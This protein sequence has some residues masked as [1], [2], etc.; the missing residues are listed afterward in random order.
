MSVARHNPAHAQGNAKALM[1]D[2]RI[3]QKN[4]YSPQ[5]QY[6]RFTHYL[7]EYKRTY[8][9]RDN[10][11]INHSFLLEKDLLKK[12]RLDNP[13]IA[14]PK[15][16]MKGTFDDDSIGGDPW[17]Y[18]RE[19]ERDG[20][21]PVG[22]KTHFNHSDLLSE[23]QETK[24]ILSNLSNKHNSQYLPLNFPQNNLTKN[25]HLNSSIPLGVPLA[26]SSTMGSQ[27]LPNATPE[28]LLEQQFVDSH[29]MLVSLLS[30]QKD[31]DLN[32]T[33]KSSIINGLRREFNYLKLN[34]TAPAKDF[35]DILTNWTKLGKPQSVEEQE[36]LNNTLSDDF[37]FNNEIQI[38]NFNDRTLLN[39]TKDKLAKLRGNVGIQ[40]QIRTALE[41][42]QN[43]LNRTISLQTNPEFYDL[44][45]NERI[46]YINYIKDDLKL[47]QER[48]DRSIQLSID[49]IQQLHQYDRIQLLPQSNTPYLPLPRYASRDLQTLNSVPYVI[50][51]RVSGDSSTA[52]TNKSTAHPFLFDTKNIFNTCMPTAIRYMQCMRS[53]QWVNDLDSIPQCNA[54]S[55]SL[56]QCQQK[57]TIN[58]QQNS[59]QSWGKIISQWLWGDENG[60]GNGEG[61]MVSPL[62]AS[63]YHPQQHNNDGGKD[64]FPAGNALWGGNPANPA[65]PANNIAQN[66]KLLLPTQID[67]KKDLILTTEQ[68]KEFHK[69]SK[70]SQV[71][72]LPLELT[73]YN[74]EQQISKQYNDQ[75]NGWFSS[76][77]FLSHWFDN[78]S[79][80]NNTPNLE[81]LTDLHQHPTHSSL[82]NAPI[83]PQ[84]ILHRQIPSSPSL[85]DNQLYPDQIDYFK[86]NGYHLGNDN[87]QD[88]YTLMGFN[89]HSRY[90]EYPTG[91][92]RYKGLLFNSDHIYQYWR[93][94]Q[95][96]LDMVS[97]DW[98][99]LEKYGTKTG[100]T[101]MRQRMRDPTRQDDEVEDLV[102]EYKWRKP[103][104][105]Q[106]FLR[107]AFAP[108]PSTFA[109]PWKIIEE[110]NDEENSR[111]KP[112]SS[113][114]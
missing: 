87:L 62:T 57:E 80:S 82:T 84:I 54:L 17:W 89:G 10:I 1:W 60:I 49:E 107:H 78:P 2:E 104:G 21:V 72:Q 45:P 97:A 83:D 67:Q 65:N 71:K 109:E 61:G 13:R 99:H 102:T 103:R 5:A 66:V 100:E 3:A 63:I 92:D 28:A 26:T 52:L 42:S 35:S 64:R 24:A 33:L 111:P 34:P 56:F 41:F 79:S 77:P 8:H 48:L 105:D 112:S 74:A 29:M 106:D 68:E 43:A 96:V 53:N 101:H 22:P 114:W 38:L 47:E 31:I 70:L 81:F 7:N 55:T 30:V 39:A 16:G 110:R 27:Y 20:K 95:E 86:Q 36:L 75:N 113:W 58:V 12:K 108:D 59:T 88:P 69:A 50:N 91:D 90:H 18:K 19:L 93:D 14:G 94:P 4:E 40:Q 98:E 9:L 23:M 51:E 25:P 76:I 37:Q 44:T 32:D 15:D 46:E 85:S 73:L 11:K 6:D